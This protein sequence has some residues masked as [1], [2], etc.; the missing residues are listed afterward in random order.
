M[1]I[2]FAF[3]GKS[4][5]QIA[6]YQDGDTLVI[7]FTYLRRGKLKYQQMVKIFN[8]DS[9]SATI[10]LYDKY[11]V[12]F[13]PK[14]GLDKEKL[15]IAEILIKAKDT[16]DIPKLYRKY[17]YVRINDSMSVLKLLENYEVEDSFNQPKFIIF[18]C[19]Q[20]TKEWLT[21]KAEENTSYNSRKRTKIELKEGTITNIYY[22]DGYYD[23]KKVFMC[24]PTGKVFCK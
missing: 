19:I 11:K 6:N 13:V 10:M 18:N 23:I 16:N 2:I 9:S 22:L 3:F 21:K 4:F 8:N 17:L 1:V 7:K 5:S 20:K 12:S 14:D 24:F 15:K